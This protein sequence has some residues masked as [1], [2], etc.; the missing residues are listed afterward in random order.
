MD[1]ETRDYLTAAS[2]RF[3]RQVWPFGFD[4]ADE[5]PDTLAKL[6]AEVKARGKMTVWSGASE[7]TIFGSAE[8]NYH[9]RAWHDWCHWRYRL[10][11]TAEGERAAAYVQVAHIARVYGDDELAAEMAAWVLAE[12]IGQAE[13][14][15]EHGEFPADQVAFDEEAV[16][17]FRP[18]AAT[19]VKALQFAG[20]R[21]AVLLAKLDPMEL[22]EV[23]VPPAAHVAEARGLS[24]QV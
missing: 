24:A 7:H 2:I 8:A 17:W 11:F 13:Y 1:P 15:A 23:D 18:L 22:E 3:A 16:S 6:R 4:V 14:Q 5:A 9:F 21:D 12:V 20:D 10:P 19:L